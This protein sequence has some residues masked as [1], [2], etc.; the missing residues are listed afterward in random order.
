MKL[1]VRD[2]INAPAREVF[3]LLRDRLV[4]IVPHMPNI[5]KIE[6]QSREEMGPQTHVVAIW[7][8][9]AD[10]PEVAKKFLKPEYLS[11]RD[12]AKWN[13]SDLSV[14]YSLD[15]SS[16]A[17]LY[18]VKGHNIIKPAGD[19]QSTLHVTCDVEIYPEKLPGLPRF[20]AAMVKKPVEET[21]RLM[22]E[23]NLKNLAKGLN[24]Y[25]KK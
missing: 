1:E 10:I 12:D 21:I 5:S 24:S 15:P 18:S 20:M 25:F 17:K 8:A 3:E 11:W 9:K 6:V 19:S 14:N 7:Y 23:P 4:E 16:S 22:L 13:E 2:T